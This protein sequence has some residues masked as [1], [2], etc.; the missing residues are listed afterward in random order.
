MGTEKKQVVS[1]KTN[2][3]FVRVAVLNSF[4]ISRGTDALKNSTSESEKYALLFFAQTLHASRS[5]IGLLCPT[6]LEQGL[7]CLPLW[8]RSSLQCLGTEPSETWAAQNQP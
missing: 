8:R 3:V 6:A 1:T 4:L 5:F 7:E 2:R